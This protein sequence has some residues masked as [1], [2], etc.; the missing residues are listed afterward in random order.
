MIQKL[1]LAAQAVEPF[2]CKDLAGWKIKGAAEGNAVPVGELH[3]FRKIFVL[4][5]IAVHFRDDVGRIVRRPI[6]FDEK[7]KARYDT[8]LGPRPL[9]LRMRVAQAVDESG[10]FAMKLDIAD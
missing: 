2:N 4:D 6:G 9:I 7:R 3:R 1:C 8:L 5:G 10:Q